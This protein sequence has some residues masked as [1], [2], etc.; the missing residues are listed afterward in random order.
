M[1]V[2]LHVS[3][4]SGNTCPD[5]RLFSTVIGY[6]CLLRKSGLRE[7]VSFLCFMF[8]LLRVWGG[9]GSQGDAWLMTR[10]CDNY[11]TTVLIHFFFLDVE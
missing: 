9:R 3:L 2:S 4:G 1:Q 10:Q 5:S 11:E 8:Y 6:K 7:Q